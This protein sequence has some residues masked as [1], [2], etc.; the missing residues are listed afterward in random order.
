MAMKA[1]GPRQE[2]PRARKLQG[3]GGILRV[4]RISYC[5]C[6]QVTAARAGATV[7]G[8]RSAAVRGQERGPGKGG[9]GAL[10]EM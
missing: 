2:A 5:R 4:V 6:A 3:T 8:R 1:I 10:E 9:G 7:G